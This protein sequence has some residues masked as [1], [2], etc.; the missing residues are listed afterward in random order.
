MKDFK[1]FTELFVVELLNELTA[2]ISALHM[3][4][5]C[6]FVQTQ[7]CNVHNIF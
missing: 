2:V 5:L 3:Y 1:T 7:S 6:D 4:Y